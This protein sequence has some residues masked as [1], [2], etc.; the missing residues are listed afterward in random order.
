MLCDNAL[1]VTVRTFNTEA[2]APDPLARVGV[3][4]V[5]RAGEDPSAARH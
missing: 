5:C 3:P 1:M 2:L 4:F